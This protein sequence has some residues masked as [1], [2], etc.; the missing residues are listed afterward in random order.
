VGR[1]SEGIS[2]TAMLAIGEARRGMQRS[3]SLL[4][5]CDAALVTIEAKDRMHRLRSYQ[6]VVTANEVVEVV[7]VMGLAATRAEALSVGQE[8]VECGMLTNVRDENDFEA[9]VPLFWK[10]ET[11]KRGRS[12]SRIETPKA[13]KP[14]RRSMSGGSGK[15]GTAGM[16]MEM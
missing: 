8:M 11:R 9:A 5:L 6:E 13:S 7:L 16:A 1:E 10:S 15:R 14:R 4:A 3:K 12:V 2:G